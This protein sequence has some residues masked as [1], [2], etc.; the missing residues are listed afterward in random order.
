MTKNKDRS[1]LFVT[2]QE[3]IKKKAKA[4]FEEEH[5]KQI[6]D[7]ANFLIK[8]TYEGIKPKVRE[9]KRSLS[10]LKDLM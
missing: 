6:C 1:K 7:Y 2:I 4:Y 8:E 5:A 3:K 9:I 10:N